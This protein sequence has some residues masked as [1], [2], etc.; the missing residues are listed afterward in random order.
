MLLLDGVGTDAPLALTAPR[1]D[2]ARARLYQRESTAT[3]VG[4]RW[5]VTAEGL[6]LSALGFAA[7]LPTNG[8]IF[9]GPG[10]EIVLVP[11]D[12]PRALKWDL[13]FTALR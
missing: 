9:P 2:D 4:Q 1:F 11:L 5:E 8:R 13:E 7:G 6:L 10:S 12:S 3:C